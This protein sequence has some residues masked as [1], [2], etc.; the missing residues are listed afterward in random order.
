[1]DPLNRKQ[2]AHEIAQRTRLNDAVVLRV[3]DQFEATTTQVLREGGTVLLS[4]FAKFTSKQQG[5]T[6]RRNP[7]TGGTVEVPPKRRVLISAGATLKR[8]VNS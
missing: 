5:A 7:Q 8:D 6:T 4:G 2:L 3:L 1:M